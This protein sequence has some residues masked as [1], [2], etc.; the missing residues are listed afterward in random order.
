MD[1]IPDRIK[2]IVYEHFTVEEGGQYAF[3]KELGFTQ[4][5]VNGWCVGRQMPSALAL[6]CISQKYG[7]SV[8]WILGLSD[9]KEV[10]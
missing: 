2:E 9:V 6:I 1:K 10:R 8:D 4:S 5:A 3:A 7:V